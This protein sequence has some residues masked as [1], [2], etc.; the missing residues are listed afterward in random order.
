[1]NKR[2]FISSTF[3]DFQAERDALRSQ[4]LPLLNETAVRYGESVDFCDLRWGIDT[5]DTDE[6]ES[7]RKVLSVCLDEIDRARPYMIVLLGE[8]YGYMPGEGPIREEAE[9]RSLALS[10]P[11][12]SVT[13]LEIE[14]GALK[15]AAAWEHTWFYLRLPQAPANGAVGED[16][17]HRERLQRLKERIRNLA[18]TRVKTYEA[19]SGA[20]AAKSLAAFSAMVTEDLRREL[21]PEWKARAGRPAWKQDHDIQWELI[22]DKE[23]AFSSFETEADCLREQLRKGGWH[24]ISGPEGCGKT[25]MLAHISCCMQTEDTTVIPVLCG[26]NSRLSSA[27]GVLSYLW[28]VFKEIAEGENTELPADPEEM[29]QEMQDMVAAAAKKQKILIAVDAPE[30]LAA[31]L[32][33]DQLRFLPGGEI[34]GV[35]VLIAGGKELKLPPYAIVYEIPPLTTDEGHKLLI[36][37]MKESGKELDAQTVSMFLSLPGASNPLWMR[38]AFSR[39]CLMDQSDYREAEAGGTD[40]KNFA[41]YQQRL[42]QGI[43]Q[44]PEGASAH[45]LQEAA[46]RLYSQMLGPIL[47]DL[48]LSRRGWRERDLRLFLNTEGIRFVPLDLVR[49]VHFFRELFLLREDGRYDFAHAGIRKGLMQDDVKRHG[50]FA[51]VLQLYPENDPVRREELLYHLYRADRRKEFLREVCRRAEHIWDEIGRSE[52]AAEQLYAGITGTRAG[53]LLQQEESGPWANLAETAGQVYDLTF[54]DQGEWILSL[55]REDEPDAFLLPHLLQLGMQLRED[56]TKERLSVRQ[57]LAAAARKYALSRSS[58]AAKTWQKTELMQFLWQ[59]AQ[60][61]EALHSEEGAAEAERLYVKALEL[62]SSL[63]LDRQ[64]ERIP[65]MLV[66]LS[67]AMFYRGSC[68]PPRLDEAEK[69]AARAAELLGQV[70]EP[71]ETDI[72]LSV[73]SLVTYCRILRD[74]NTVQSLAGARANIG[75]ARDILDSRNRGKRVQD[76]SYSWLVCEADAL[77]EAAMLAETGAIPLLLRSVAVTEE[78]LRRKPARDLWLGLASDYSRLGGLY[79]KED[80][81]EAVNIY[82]K[83][84]QILDGL[85]RQS[86]TRRDAGSVLNCLLRLLHAAGEN[87]GLKREYLPEAFSLAQ[88]LARGGL[89]DVNRQ[90]ILLAYLWHADAAAETPGEIGAETEYREMIRLAETMPD[91]QT[92]PELLSLLISAKC[93]LTEIV[94]RQFGQTHSGRYIFEAALLRREILQLHLKQY[95]LTQALDDAVSLATAAHDLAQILYI[96]NRLQNGRECLSLQETAVGILQPLAK[97]DLHPEARYYYLMCGG[98]LASYREE[99]SDTREQ[100]QQAVAWYRDFMAECEKYA[101]YDSALESLLTQYVYPGGV[102]LLKNHGGLSGRM[103]AGKLSR[104]MKAG[105][106]K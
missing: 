59:E 25:A 70:K 97:D 11:D 48:A 24:L 57:K 67:L 85:R 37:L 64:Q 40:R 100:L 79:E 34:P 55:M 35:T 6:A 65:V 75:V 32:R 81:S 41:L 22:R 71:T 102:T 5:L 39:L 91:I 21:E 98:V 14:Y 47:R 28:H 45:L 51:D 38:M 63:P 99:F 60:T 9:R 66:L 101:G 19:P 92:R 94:E 58:A 73:S 76:I 50:L 90:N 4:V 82:R 104:K 46:A 33:R 15:D 43:P 62:S 3:S 87:R 61:E 89:Q 86:G 80:P 83:E 54:T 69:C 20:D 106:R 18:G 49:M 96:Q 68:Q 52:S 26:V 72:L 1:M 17:R 12:I 36:S 44:T 53:S 93:S 7:S 30:R 103:L 84:Y 105:I 23:R 16:A 31:D 77:S 74:R 88:V 29:L 78:L 56:Y 95:E 8:R 42:L 2:I 13:H 27:R 10:E